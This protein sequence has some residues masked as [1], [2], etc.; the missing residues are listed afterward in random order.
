MKALFLVFH[1]FESH[2][3]ISKK[4]F[5]Q[6]NGMKLCGVNTVL[7]YLLID[8]KGVHKRMADD[9]I[10]E[11]YGKGILAK[12]KKRIFYNSLLLYILNNNIQIVYVRHDLN[13]NPFL[14]YFFKTLK[15]NNIKV[16]LEIPTYPYDHEY[17]HA[18]W[19]DLLQNK[20]D[21]LFR[22]RLA[23]NIFRIVTFT[24]LFKIWGVPTIRISNGIDFNKVRIK[25][26]DNNSKE[27]LNLIGVADI[28]AWHGFD[29]VIR[30][31]ADYYKGINPVKVYFHIIGGG[32]NQLVNELKHLTSENKLD[33]YVIF[34]GPQ[35]GDNLNKLFDI[36]NFGIAS[37]ARHRS[38]ISNIKT[39]KNREYAARGIPFIYSE[40]D[41]D[42]ENMPYILKAPANE[43]AINIQEIIDFYAKLKI[44][45][46]EI[47]NSISH[48]SWEK[49]MQKVIDSI[50][51]SNT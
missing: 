9:T 36:A 1:G 7:S 29:R 17:L 35:S 10:V 32:I 23:K 41:S 15:N 30:G 5:Y 48:L 11:N 28:H 14:V 2:N 33:K 25:Q 18:K 38:K 22:R 19:K 26:N 12:I 6:V 13:A 45:A 49:Q 3:G 39:L 4:I 51:S 43:D 47:R 27:E 31:L 44:S 46:Q 40:I 34:H 50:S 21:K 8:K 24:D 42:F 37:L 20:I 16:I